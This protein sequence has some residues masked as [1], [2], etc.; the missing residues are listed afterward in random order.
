[1][2]VYTYHCEECDHEFDQRQSFSDVNL[3]D[4]PNCKKSEVL[5]KIYKP[6][7]IVFKGSGYYVTD[8]RGKQSTMNSASKPEAKKEKSDGEKSTSADKSKTKDTSAS[9]KSTE[10]K[11]VAKKNE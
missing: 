6:A 2:P 8:N 4:C 1:M 3:T 9:T 7:Q 10:K 5:Y 11:T